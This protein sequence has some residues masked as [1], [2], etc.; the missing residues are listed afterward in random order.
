MFLTGVALILLQGIVVQKA[1][2]HSL[3]ITATAACSNGAPVI[4]YTVTSWDQNPADP[5]GTNP[6]SR[7]SSME[8][9]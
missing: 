5:G 4:S 8:W 3:T 7:S 6:Q 2:A 1:Y 9:W